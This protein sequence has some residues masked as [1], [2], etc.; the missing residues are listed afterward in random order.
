VLR[1]ALRRAAAE[2]RS[3][4][5]PKAELLAPAVRPA[6]RRLMQMLVEAEQFRERLAIEIASAELHRG[7][8]TERIFEALVLINTRGERPD[9]A[10]LA[11]ALE[12]RD[13]R[14]LFEVLFEPIAEATWEEA[15]SCLG[16]LR[17][18]TLE[19]ELV[20]LQRQIEAQTSS[21]ELTRL[22]VR[23][24]ELQKMLARR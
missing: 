11:G 7:L 17:S 24:L 19:Q 18:R 22:L 12:E 2:R 8:D 4:V 5:K 23:R 1:E 10:A 9:A 3:E 6:E 21:E 16:V 20:D 13:R 15:E 14:V